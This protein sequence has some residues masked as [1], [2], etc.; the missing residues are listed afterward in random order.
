MSSS[1]YSFNLTVS[2]T[3]YTYQLYSY[4]RQNEYVMGA[5]EGIEWDE[6]YRIGDVI[7]GDEYN[8]DK[9]EIMHFHIFCNHEKDNKVVPEDHFICEINNIVAD[10]ERKAYKFVHFRLYKICRTLS[11][12]MNMYNQHKN[13]FQPRVEIDF[14]SLLWERQVYG[15]NNTLKLPNGDVVCMSNAILG[16]VT[17]VYT[18]GISDISLDKF[19]MYF[20]STDLELNYM[21]DE[22]YLALGKEDVRS[23]FFHLFSIIEFI[24]KRYIELSGAKP[25]L[26]EEE[27][28]DLVEYTSEIKMDI[29]SD[30]KKR[31]VGTIK[32]V[33]SKMTDQGRDTKLVNILNSMGIKKVLYSDKQILINKNMI[34][35]MTDL[36]NCLFHGDVG[37]SREGKDKEIQ[38]EVEKLLVICGMII[39]WVAEMQNELIKK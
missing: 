24:E 18:K 33:L 8:L 28:K 16:M 9:T 19:S 14:D 22:F 12:I 15:E 34:S 39:E 29:D 10:G 37:E 21:L 27:V 30:K 31:I 38:I 5:Y 36:R 1:L 25:L 2:L 32:G 3:Y 26:T 4:N 11:I 23:K 7:E 20:N 35:Q 6:S 17:R 13:Y